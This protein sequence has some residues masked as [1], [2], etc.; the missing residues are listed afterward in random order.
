MSTSSEQEALGRGRRRRSRL[1]GA[2]LV[3]T[4]LCGLSGW[5]LW[6]ASAPVEEPRPQPRREA[7]ANPLGA[8]FTPA[9]ARVAPPPVHPAIVREEREP[10]PPPVPPEPTPPPAAP[11]VHLAQMWG[12]PGLKSRIDVA[13]R[14]RGGGT[15]GREGDYDRPGEEP[16][17]FQ[18]RMRSSRYSPAQPSPVRFNATYTIPPGTKIN[19]VPDS[20]IS[21][22]MVGPVDC[23]VQGDVRSMDGTMVLVPDNSRVHG[24]IEKGLANGERRLFIVW[25]YAITPGPDWLMIPLDAPGADPMGQMGVPGDLDRRI[26]ERYGPTLALS[27]IDFG[28]G[29]AASALRDTGGS[30]INFGSIGNTTGRTLGQMA[31]ERDQNIPPVVTRGPAR[32]LV[33]YVP[34]PIDLRKFYGLQ[35][36]R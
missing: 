30:V 28:V 7:S 5:Y 9:T 1:M 15:G 24:M 23:S 18:Q 10:V 21:S 17:E 13:Q 11:R 22:E 6:R 32:T 35:E 4:A 27:V 25:Q 29:A 3:T 34:R 19:C 8:E 16:T 31:F 33:V 14:P 36:V 20:P 12:A 2:M 26:W